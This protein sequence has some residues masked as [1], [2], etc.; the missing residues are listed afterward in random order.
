MFS[1]VYGLEDKMEDCQNCSVL[2]CVPQ[3]YSV[4][5][6]HVS[7]SYTLIALGLVF[8]VC[9]CVLLLNR[10]SLFIIG[11]VTLCFC[12]LFGCQYQHIKGAVQMSEDRE[13]RRKF[14]GSHYGPTDHG[15]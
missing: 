2:Y 7:S 14:V 1:G 9:F 4:M 13:V 12:V 6:T 10:V 11:L 15:T 5:H 3:L 8:S